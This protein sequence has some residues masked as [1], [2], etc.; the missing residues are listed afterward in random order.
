MSPLAPSGSNSSDYFE[1]DDP[2]FLHALQTAIL[3]GDISFSSSNTG[4]EQLAK[5]S[6]KRSRSVSEE[7]G[8]YEIK[9]HQYNTISQEDD[10][11]G[12]SHF[13]QFGEYMR[14]KRA[15]LQIQNAEL[16]K[17]TEAGVGGE[18]KMFSGLAIYVRIHVRSSLPSFS[19]CTS[20]KRL[21]RAFCA[22]FASTDCSPW[23]D[24]SALSG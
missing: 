7:L 4:Q 15:K 8:I 17:P 13:G 21:D 23:W 1:N 6:L 16:E 10:T 5:T 24:I 14:R 9:A 22:G 11:Y 12:P 2:E 19:S 3:P 18:N 20:D